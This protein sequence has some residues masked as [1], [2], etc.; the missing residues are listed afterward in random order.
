[1]KSNKLFQKSLKVIFPQLF[2]HF[3]LG[4]H[5]IFN[6]IDCTQMNLNFPLNLLEALKFNVFYYWNLELNENAGKFQ[7]SFFLIVCANCW[8]KLA[9]LPQK[10]RMNKITCSLERMRDWLTYLDS[11][12]DFGAIVI[13]YFWLSGSRVWALIL[14]RVV[15]RFIWNFYP[16][17]W[18][19]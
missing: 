16:I 19:L 5:K 6:D 1:M 4:N 11:R 3:P 15:V 18:H 17:I 2:H 10:K 13:V 7:N 14:K 8:T 12:V 9:R